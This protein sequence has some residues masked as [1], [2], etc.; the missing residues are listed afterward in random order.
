M[1]QR[2]QTDETKNLPSVLFLNIS[3]IADRAMN[4]WVEPYHQPHCSERFTGARKAIAEALRNHPDFELVLCGHSLGAGVA[5]LLNIKLHHDGLDKLAQEIGINDV[6]VRCVAV[7][8]PPVFCKNKNDPQV[9]RVDEAIKNTVCYMHQDDCVPFLS[10]HVI[11]RLADTLK[12]VDGYTADM[13]QVS[14]LMVSRGI[15]KAPAILWGIVWDGSKFLE[16]KESADS[17]SIPAQSVLWFQRS[18]KENRPDAPEKKLPMYDGWYCDPQKLKVL[19]FYMSPDMIT[20]HLMP[21]YERATYSV[22]E[23]RKYGEPALFP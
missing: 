20:D 22:A 7:A 5:C 15:M 4:L 10:A 23:Q 14:R 11:R 8:S 6:R 12:K 1:K 9:D 16:E 21:A 18:G 3:G 2:N 13:A 19:S 17:L